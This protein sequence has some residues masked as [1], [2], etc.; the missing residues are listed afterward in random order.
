MIRKNEELI[1]FD[2][3]TEWNKYVGRKESRQGKSQ[4]KELTKWYD[5]EHKGREQDEGGQHI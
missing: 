3:D 2:C 5:Y 1:L 4:G